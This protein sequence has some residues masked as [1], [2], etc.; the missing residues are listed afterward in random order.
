MIR[1][2]IHL[3][4]TQHQW[5][6]SLVLGALPISELRGAIPVGVMLGMPLWQAFLW[7]VLGNLLPV[8]FLLLFFKRV[9]ALGRRFAPTRRFFDWVMERTRKNTAAIQRYE[10]VG[11]ALFVAIPIPMTGAW[12]GAVAASVLEMPFGLAVS[13]IVVGV[14]TAGVAVSL[15]VHF[16]I[17]FFYAVF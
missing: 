5:L 8:P 17:R 9:S 14:L 1:Q 3:L 11:L 12:S 6:I 13:S 10:A 4:G 16:G 2:I 7:S 15:A